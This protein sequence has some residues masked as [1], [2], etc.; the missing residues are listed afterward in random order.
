MT[1]IGTRNDFLSSAEFVISSNIGSEEERRK[2]VEQ[3]CKGSEN[4]E[5]MGTDDTQQ[6]RTIHIGREIEE[7][8]ST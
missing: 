4:S 3:K 1:R 2:I 8:K 6:V 7:E 5:R